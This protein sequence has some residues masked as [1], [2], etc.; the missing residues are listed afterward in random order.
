MRTDSKE[1]ETR[2]DRRTSADAAPPEGFAPIALARCD[3]DAYARS[4]SQLRHGELWWYVGGLVRR[5]TTR[6]FRDSSGRWWYAIKPGF[7][8]PVNFF[9]SLPPDAASLGWRPIL[10]AQWP[11]E[12]QHANSRVWMNVARD[13]GGYG[14]SRVDSDKR[15]AVRKGLRGLSILPCDPADAQVAAEAREVWNSHVQRTGWNRPYEPAEFTASW[16][17]LARMP[18]TTVLAARDRATGT[19]CAWLIVRAIDDVAY[20]DTLASHTERLEHRPNDAIVFAAVASAAA[21]GVRHA[22]YSLRSSIASLE[23]FK[24]SLGFEPTAFPTRL[25]LRWAVRRVLAWKKPHLLRRLEGG[26]NWNTPPGGS[27]PAASAPTSSA[28]AAGDVDRPGGA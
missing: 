19:L 16:S 20:M 18:G 23:A 6:P 14:L 21:A 12:P 22:H 17:E 11:V 3:E 13:I 5:G 4:A 25:R 26:E 1:P 24:R 10:G 15:R 2:G 7:I 9:A 8:W 28:P 27:A